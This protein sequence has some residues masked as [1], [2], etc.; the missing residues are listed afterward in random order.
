MINNDYINF[1]AGGG[2]HPRPSQLFAD[3]EGTTWGSGWTATGDFAGQG[4]LSS[5]LPNQ[6]GA[7]VLDTFVGGG[8]SAM[9]AIRSPEFTITRD[10]INFLIAGGNHP[11]AASGTTAVNLIVDNAVL[12]TTTGND[13]STMT[14]VSWDVHELIGRKAH[15]EIIDH[16]TGSWGH[17]MVDQILFSSVPNAV[18]GEA[19][20]QTTVNLLVNGNVVRTTSGQ[21]SEHLTW[22][23]WDVRD[24]AGQTAQIR[25]IDNNSGSWGH[26]LADQI[27]FAGTPAT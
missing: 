16:A 17:L 1:L 5:S 14:N 4:P 27:T 11:W 8:D 15:I 7:K 2:D 24:L 22:S 6:I 3:F 9:G 18:V 13:S 10:Y 23:T 25:I 20:T 19:D 12:R 21:G 26:I